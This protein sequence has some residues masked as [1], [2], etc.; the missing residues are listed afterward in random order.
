MHATT[1]AHGPAPCPVHTTRTIPE[2]PTTRP[3]AC[4]FETRS[5]KK[6]MANAAIKM[7]CNPV[8]TAVIPAPVPS[9]IPRNTP[10]K[11]VTCIKTPTITASR[12][13]T[14]VLGQGARAYK[15]KRVNAVAA[16]A[17][18]SDKNV[19]GSA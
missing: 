15:D 16:M 18:R 6:G 2:N 10:P 1:P 8:M 12:I 19:N 11:Y 5:A 4:N 7:G 9:D 14:N 3:K 17:N 13:S